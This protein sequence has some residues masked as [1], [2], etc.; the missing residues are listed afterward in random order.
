MPKNTFNEQELINL[1]D[2]TLAP[3]SEIQ[4]MKFDEFFCYFF[5][6]QGR[7]VMGVVIVFYIFVNR[8]VAL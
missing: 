2:Y 5:Y 6:V 1:K 4:F 7:Q 8:G 3:L